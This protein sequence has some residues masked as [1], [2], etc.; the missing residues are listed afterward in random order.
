MKTVL[1]GFIPVRKS[2]TMGNEFGVSHEFDTRRTEAEL[3][4]RTDFD[5]ENP[6]DRI[7]PCTLTIET[8]KNEW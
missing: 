7:A 3:Y 2:K 5:K 4:T 1:R 8:V 6:V